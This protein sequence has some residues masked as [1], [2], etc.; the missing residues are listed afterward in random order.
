MTL[1]ALVGTGTGVGKTTIAA[2]LLRAL[3]LQGICPAIFKPVETGVVN[4][5]H[6]DAQIL[7]SVSGQPLSETLGCSFPLPAAP[8]AAARAHGT[9]VSLPTL[10]RR[11]K[12]LGSSADPVLLEGAGGLLVPFADHVLFA[13]LLVEWRAEALVVGRLG[14]GTINHTLLT[15]SELR[16]REI[17]TL[18]VVLCALDPPGP[19]AKQTPEILEEF[20]D[21]EVFAVIPHGMTDPDAV[22]TE[23]SQT[24]LPRLITSRCRNG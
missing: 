13:D 12:R 7:S 22:S 8:L 23:L 4:A 9:D 18:G 15:L 2:G 17:K 11:L 24:N 6:S 19:E 16:R 14:L 1:L 5:Q 3:R 20:G 10:E 21:I